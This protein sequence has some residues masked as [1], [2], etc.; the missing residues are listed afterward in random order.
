MRGHAGLAALLA[1]LPAL[2]AAGAAA[3]AAPPSRTEYEQPTF[4]IAMPP[5]WRRVEWTDCVQ[6]TAVSQGWCYGL[7]RF[8]DGQGAFFQVLVDYPPTEASAHAYW[9]LAPS[10]DG[11]GLEVAREDRPRACPL[12]L[13]GEG[14]CDRRGGIT[15]A[16]WIELRGHHYL[17]GFGH[18]K[19]RKGVELAP[20][21]EMLR[22][23]RAR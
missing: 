16:A 2:A 20:F 3:P 14:P 12:T 21:R 10:A 8:E 17:F 15:V 5:G 23:F 9:E 11:A 7:A 18:A 22:S 13:E 19:R 1:C 4:R 6:D